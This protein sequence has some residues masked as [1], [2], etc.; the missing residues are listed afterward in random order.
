[1]LMQTSAM[2]DINERRV[3]EMQLFW[4]KSQSYHVAELIAPRLN[5]VLA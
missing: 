5:K 1:M 4:R 3:T 2:W